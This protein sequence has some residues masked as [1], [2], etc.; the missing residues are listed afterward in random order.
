M[1]LWCARAI[2]LQLAFGAHIEYLRCGGGR[3]WLLPPGFTGCEISPRQHF[4]CGASFIFTRI[5]A[6]S[7]LAAFCWGRGLRLVQKYDI[8]NITF[9]IT[10]RV[11]PFQYISRDLF[12]WPFGLL[13]WLRGSLYFSA[14]YSCLCWQI[15]DTPI[16][17]ILCLI[18]IDWLKSL[19]HAI[20][21]FCRL[22]RHIYSYCFAYF[23]SFNWDYLF[24]ISTPPSATMRHVL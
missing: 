3:A 5:L 6:A 8:Y 22:H 13:L 16:H 12:E 24:I 4:H 14:Y 20:Y 1:L 23:I 17:S 7:L 15:Y 10:L 18:C 11:T 2:R 9:I 21:R 19:H